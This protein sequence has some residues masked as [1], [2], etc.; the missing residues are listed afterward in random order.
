[1]THYA[2]KTPDTSYTSRSKYG[3]LHRYGAGYL[4]AQEN[5]ADLSDTDH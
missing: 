4:H 2:D 5:A 1:M 3:S